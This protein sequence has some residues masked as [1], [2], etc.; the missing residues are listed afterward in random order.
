MDVAAAEDDV[1]RLERGDQTTDDVRDVTPPLCQPVLLQP[2]H[3][4]IVLE[5]PVEIRQVAQ[6]QWFHDAL[7]DDGGAEPGAES[8][9]E[10]L[11]AAV[12]S[13]RLHRGIV[14]DLD[15]TSQG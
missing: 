9:E 6:L 12:A 14:D 13:E 2:A 10:Q 1:F 4:D 15:R 11:A 7:D 3:S 5:R 8:E